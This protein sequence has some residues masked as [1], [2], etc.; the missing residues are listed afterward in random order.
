[1][2]KKKEELIQRNRGGGR[3]FVIETSLGRKHKRRK[4]PTKT[5]QNN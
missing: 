1:M 3:N 2:N 4:G 5:N